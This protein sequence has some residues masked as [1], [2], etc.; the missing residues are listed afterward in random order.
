MCGIAGMFH[1]DGESP[2]PGSVSPLIQAMHHRGPDGTGEYIQDG[3]ALAFTR[4]A[5]IDVAGGQQ[6]IF[7]EDASIAIICN[8]EIYNHLEHRERLEAMGHSFR[9]HSDVEVILH[10]YEES[11]PDCFSQLNGMFAVA[12]ADFRRRN[13]ILARD[14][15]GQKPLYYSRDARRLVFASE[16]QAMLA[17]PEIPWDLS[18]NALQSYLALRYVPAPQSIVQGVHKLPPGSYAVANGSGSFETTRY[19]HLDLGP[20]VR[21]TSRAADMQLVLVEAVQRHLMS[22]RPLGVFLSGGLDSSTIVACMHQLGHRDIHTFTI[23][24]EGY[25]DNE[26]ENA[27]RIAE[28]FKTSHRE[29]LVSP[30]EYWNSIERVAA[31]QGDPLADPASILFDALCCG[32]AEDVVVVLSGEGSD[33]L[34][35]GYNG[36]EKLRGTFDR[37]HVLR[38]FRLL[39]EGLAQ[40]PLPADMARKV[41]SVLMTDSEYMAT[42]V[43]EFEGGFDYAFRMQHDAPMLKACN[44]FTTQEQ[45]YRE[46]ADWDG[47]HLNLGL[48]VEWW[49]P[50]ELLQRADRI[51]MAHS[52]EIRCPFLDTKF[53]DYCAH[54]PLDDKV[55]ARRREPVRKI[56]LKKAFK[57]TL[58]AGIALQ[59]KKGFVSAIYDWMRGVYRERVTAEM[60]RSD[61]LSARFLP[62]DVRLEVMNR[63]FQG[64]RLSQE[65]LWFLFFLNLWGN[66]WQEKKRLHYARTEAVPPPSLSRR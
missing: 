59:R 40:L 58:P 45:F 7:N 1:F 65:R 48:L 39:A 37:L 9:T 64:D 24:C 29:I 27:R 4:L 61:S 11:G 47:V 23:G 34:L 2:S 36:L 13:L 43:Y 41:R 15:C 5:I 53:I 51:G 30:E 21:A 66:Q 33:E 12:I 14:P 28:H 26:F 62:H 25:L 42:K 52:I 18:D 57:D 16:L 20:K 19:W 63:A 22:E 54:L 17:V 38:R 6:P 46:R 56:A 3:I 49:L 8:G 35:A 44:V 50:D 55:R 32:A 10:L 60:E 31:I